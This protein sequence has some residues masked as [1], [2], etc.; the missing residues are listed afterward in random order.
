MGSWRGLGRAP[1]TRLLGEAGERGRAGIEGMRAAH[2][3]RKWGALIAP[4]EAAG[5]GPA[6]RPPPRFPKSLG[7]S[8]AQ[9]S[10]TRA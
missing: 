7:P 10:V 2:Q 1:A 6:P 9:G 5:I 4:P 3:E 8:R